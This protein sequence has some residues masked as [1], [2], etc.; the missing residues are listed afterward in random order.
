M[1]ARITTPVA[2]HSALYYNENKVGEK[3]AELI[4]ASNFILDK[5]QL[6]LVQKKER[7]T[8]L[9][10]LNKEPSYKSLH[11]SLNFHP[12]E[13]FPRD[14]LIEI[15]AEYMDGIGFG[16][17][18]YLVYQHLDAG[19]PHM[20]IVSTNVLPD[21]QLI[22]M[23][24]IGRD[25]SEPARKEL[26]KKYHLVRAEDQKN[27]LASALKPVDAQRLQYGK[28]ET[29]RGITNVLDHVLKQY[30]FTSLAELNAILR[31]YNLRADPGQPGARI[32][33]HKGL[34]YQITDANG[35]GVGVRIKASSIYSKPTLANL[36]K[37]FEKNKIKRE[38]DLKTLRSAIDVV[39]RSRP[40]HWDQ[41]IKD[42]KAEKVLV[43]P[44]INDQGRL[45]GISF[46]DLDTKA[47]STGSGLGKQYGATA[48]LEK[49][50]LDPLL[51][52]MPIPA[53]VQKKARTKASGNNQGSLW[54]KGK[55]EQEQTASPSLAGE[56]LEIL[57]RQEEQNQ[58]LPFE[59]RKDQ[60]KRKKPSL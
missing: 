55:N 16:D 39:I 11:V 54:P 52:K 29:K 5:D 17:Q 43:I 57:L 19:H 50:G 30:K 22:S 32:Q 26:E 49:L 14:Q 6:T 48:I 45:Y 20:H 37:L 44:Y 38:P 15:A 59:L 33:H 4:H 28:S 23:H 8:R 27:K 36:E 41:F 2:R 13:Q 47:I 3:A 24:N 46:L 53:K 18:P 35:K 60:K 51:Q 58:Q 31:L 34:L 21:G 9:Y 42:L 10:D 12:S 1:V 40:A 25:K 56:A 7:F